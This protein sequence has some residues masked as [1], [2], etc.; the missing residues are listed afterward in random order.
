MR[1]KWVWEKGQRMWV[2]AIIMPS[3]EFIFFYFL[4]SR[5]SAIIVHKTLNW[6][7]CGNQRCGGQIS[8]CF[9]FGSPLI[10]WKFEHGGC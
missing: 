6:I 7:P 9:S 4:F 5:H 8:P 2:E 3:N 1:Q 10:L